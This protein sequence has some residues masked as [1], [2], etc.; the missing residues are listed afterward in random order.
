M[1]NPLAHTQVLSDLSSD[2]QSDGMIRQARVQLSV[3]HRTCGTVH[4]VLLGV[5]TGGSAGMYQAEQAKGCD[6]HLND[7]ACILQLRDLPVDR[8][9]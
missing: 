1:H 3:V 6:M 9:W 8:S 5:S 2:T 4:V 7:A